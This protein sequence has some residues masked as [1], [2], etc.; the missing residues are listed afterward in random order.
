MGSGPVSPI[1]GEE[2]ALIEGPT[3]PAP[4][5]QPGTGAPV[6]S[7]GVYPDVVNNPAV[8]DPMDL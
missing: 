4:Y 1:P 5:V 8:M 2:S 6:Q 7:S 3:A